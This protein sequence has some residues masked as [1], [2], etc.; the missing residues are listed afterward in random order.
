MNYERGTMNYGS[1]LQRT[2][3]ILFYA[4]RRGR[5]PLRVLNSR[6]KY[7]TVG[8]DVRFGIPANA[9][10]IRGVNPHRPVNCSHGTD[11]RASR[12]TLTMK[13]P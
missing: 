3:N 11:V 4:G 8:T 9:T 1:F 12:I 13:N 7:R 2:K 10:S 6:G 5:R